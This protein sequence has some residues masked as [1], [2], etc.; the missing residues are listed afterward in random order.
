[1]SRLDPIL[2][3]L[4]MLILSALCGCGPKAPT[5][6]IPNFAWVERGHYRGG[7]PPRG[8]A[9]DY[10]KNIGVERII[11]LDEEDL[12]IERSEASRVGIELIYA[13]ISLSDQLFGGDSLDRAVRMAEAAFK[14]HGISYVHCKN[15]WDR[16]GLIV[17]LYRVTKDGWEPHR[18]YEEM[19]AFG[20]HWQLMGL[21]LYFR[22]HS[23][24]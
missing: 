14:L 10:L 20:F 5:A 19:E 1:M 23:G 4:A 21:S 18:A 15:G 9:F 16:T 7:Q 24:E 17:G 2:F 11:K 22:N 6:Q 12:A 3:L 13:P 8:E